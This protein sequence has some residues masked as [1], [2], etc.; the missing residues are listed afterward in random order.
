MA[1]RYGPRLWHLLALLRD[2]CQALVES[3]PDVLEA[4]HNLEEAVN[5][6]FPLDARAFGRP[7][8][9][10][11]TRIRRLQNQ[12]QHLRQIKMTLKQQLV[13]L[14][15]GKQKQDNNRLTP[16]FFGEGRTFSAH[17]MC[18]GLCFGMAGFGGRW[19]ARM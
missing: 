9:K 4:L 19:R 13:E 1:P 11:T 14:T 17:H 10:V 15:V 8:V 2:S 7:P 16:E 18:Q 5:V 6:G 3:H 12:V